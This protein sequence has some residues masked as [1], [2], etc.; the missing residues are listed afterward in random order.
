MAQPRVDAETLRR[1]LADDHT[2]AD[3][4]RHFGVSEKAISQRIKKLTSLTSRVVVLERASEV[5]DQKLI[6]TARGSSACS[7]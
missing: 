3:V 4:A 2:Q 6:A 7:R 1:F 5:V